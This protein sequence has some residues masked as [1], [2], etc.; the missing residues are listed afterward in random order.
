M[1]AAVAL[2]LAMVAGLNSWI[3]LVVAVMRPRTCPMTM[4]QSATP[5]PPQP[6]PQ[7]ISQE[8]IRFNP[9]DFN[10]WLLALILIS[11]II[12]AYRTGTPIDLPPIQVQTAPGATVQVHGATVTTP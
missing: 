4:D 5:I 6:L 10:S 8:P 1:T 2:W 9:R 12:A 3:L 7:L 11:N